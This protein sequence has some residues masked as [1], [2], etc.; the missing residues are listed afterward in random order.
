[1]PHYR[2]ISAANFLRSTK[3]SR[4]IHS[5]ACSE[6]TLPRPLQSE[7]HVMPKAFSVADLPRSLNTRLLSP[8]AS[9]DDELSFRSIYK[10]GTNFQEDPLSPPS[11]D[12]EDVSQSLDSDVKFDQTSLSSFS[13][14]SFRRDGSESSGIR[15]VI[16]DDS[17]PF[18]IQSHPVQCPKSRRIAHKPETPSFKGRY[19]STGSPYSS[20]TTSSDRYISSRHFPQTLSETFH[21]SKSPHLLSG[22]EK[23]FRKK[24][25]APD[26]FGP[27]SPQRVRERAQHL[28]FDSRGDR[29]DIHFRAANGASLL[30]VSTNVVQ[31]ESRHA[32]TGSVWNIGGES[33]T[34][35]QGP[36]RSIPDGRGGWVGSGTNAPFYTADFS[37][38]KAS[39]END[40]FYEG[41]LAVALDIDHAARLLNISQS[42][43][44]GRRSTSIS[45]DMKCKFI[46]AE[47][48]TKWIGG[49]WVRDG[50]PSRTFPTFCPF[51][52]N[53]YG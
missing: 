24:A 29:N 53:L 32:S 18:P 13:S 30:S 2:S 51:A 42:P 27:I 15:N 12:P 28:P 50:S 52:C 31:I 6:T 5:R 14:P 19:F 37:G 9:D 21:T 49:E 45:A 1:M 23:L 8:P 17:F 44:R 11:S 20:S 36:V 26:P 35:P 46:Y 22:A 48:R 10:A 7:Y 40:G 41:R 38:R 34:P 39:A 3:S 33:A 16:P 25:C 4:C 47:P 43:E